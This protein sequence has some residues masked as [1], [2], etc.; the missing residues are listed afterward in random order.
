MSQRA[1]TIHCLLSF[2]LLLLSVRAAPVDVGINDEDISQPISDNF[3]TIRNNSESSLSEI[4]KNITE[5]RS[6]TT[7]P[8]TLGTTPTTQKEDA[9][10]IIPSNESGVKVDRSNPKSPMFLLYEVERDVQHLS[11]E[12]IDY[13]LELGTDIFSYS[14]ADKLGYLEEENDPHISVIEANKEKLIEKLKNIKQK[15]SPKSITR[16]SVVPVIPTTPAKTEEPENGILKSKIA[17]DVTT[18][19]HKLSLEAVESLLGFDPELGGLPYA[20]SD[21]LGYNADENDVYFQYLASKE[22]SVLRGILEM[23][24]ERKLDDKMNPSLTDLSDNPTS[25]ETPEDL[26]I[27]TTPSDS[28][29]NNGESDDGDRNIEISPINGNSNENEGN[30]NNNEIQP[31]NG[32]ENVDKDD[33]SKNIEISPINGEDENTD[34]G[35]E[36]FTESNE[37][38]Y[39]DEI[40]YKLFDEMMTN[41]DFLDFIYQSEPEIYNELQEEVVDEDTLAEL[42]EE[43]REWIELDMDG[44]GDDFSEGEGALEPWNETELEEEDG[45]V[46]G[47]DEGKEG[48]IEVEVN[49]NLMEGNE[50][51]QFVDSE[52]GDDYEGMLVSFVI[53]ATV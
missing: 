52:E 16:T 45:L 6:F 36:E 53:I 30:G 1:V 27:D 34:V 4:R 13:V 46:E 12:D 41:K 49:V 31:I 8:P 19:I 33:G 44:K 28:P 38:E 18:R 11:L 24:K 14:L 43:Y 5:P 3:T 35:G 22:D 40:D 9:P 17:Y 7:A 25:T 29:G 21:E 48:S 37:E 42:L 23:E 26:S 15:L 47:I 51:V 20:L 2:F 50:N 10:L 39:P 32:D